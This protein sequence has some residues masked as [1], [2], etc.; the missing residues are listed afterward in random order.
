M[1][2]SGLNGSI[3]EWQRGVIQDHLLWL[4]G[5][6]SH[7]YYAQGQTKPAV[8]LWLACSVACGV[9]WVRLPALANG[10]V[11][12]RQRR[13]IQDYLLR[14]CGFESHCYYDT[15]CPSVSKQEVL[16]YT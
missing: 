8:V 12:E 2:A 14:L 1:D 6:E 16:I 10:S 4:R 15:V 9:D 13:V 5:F 11:P 7:H 3:P